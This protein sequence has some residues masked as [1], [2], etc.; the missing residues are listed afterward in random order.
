M[1]PKESQ[2]QSRGMRFGWVAA[3]ALGAALVAGDAGAGVN[4]R[5]HNQRHRIRDGVVDGSVTPG[6]RHHLVQ[7]QRRIERYEQRSRRDDGHLGPVER[8]R[9]DHMLD[10]SSR[11]IYRA[12][13]N[14]RE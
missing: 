6:E 13:H 5:E 14:D 4:G 3:L 1:G 8:G 9:L 7:Q 10:R 12:K 11:H 2:M